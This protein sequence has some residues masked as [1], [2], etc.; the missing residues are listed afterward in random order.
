VPQTLSEA[1]VTIPRGLARWTAPQGHADIAPSQFGRIEN[2][3]YL[4]ID[5]H[6]II[7][8]LLRSVPIEGRVLEPSA[9]RGHI[10]LEL[11]RAGLDVVSRDIRRYLVPLVDGIGVGDIRE[12]ESLAGFDWVVTNLPYRDLT[13]LTAH[14]TRL[15]ARDGC[16]VALLVRAEWLFPKARR[17]LV[18]EH[19]HFAGAVMLTARP[20][21]FERGDND[22]G[23]RHNSLGR[24]GAERR[25]SATGGSASS[26]SRSGSRRSSP[27]FRK[28]RDQLKTV[29]WPDASPAKP[30]SDELTFT[31]KRR[32]ADITAGLVRGRHRG[33]SR[34]PRQLLTVAYPNRATESV[35]LI[36]GNCTR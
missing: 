15:G 29:I 33:W 36:S 18:H 11:R 4:T 2:D 14:L 34:P 22:A 21:W 12:L 26:A 5:A 31:A 27:C 25:A 6:W 30:E 8:A 1:A 13:E 24:C 28:G 35:P 32:A 10:S 3:G 7:P 19:P 9:G 23:P 16:G 17:R 20:R